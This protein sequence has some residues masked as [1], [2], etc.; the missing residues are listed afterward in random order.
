VHQIGAIR[1]SDL[2][3]VITGASACFIAGALL[4]AVPAKKLLSVDA[5]TGHHI[6]ARILAQTGDEQR[7]VAAARFFY[8]VF[9]LLVWGFGAVWAF[10]GTLHILFG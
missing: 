4:R 3:W 6:Y 10:A 5:M 1:V 2:L 7:A 8:R 9:G